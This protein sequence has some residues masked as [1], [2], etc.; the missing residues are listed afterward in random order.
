MKKVSFSAPVSVPIFRLAICALLI[1]S[2]SQSANARD[3]NSSNPSGA[4]FAT[5]AADGGRLF[6]QRS[7]VLG[8]NVS[9][10]LTIDGKPAGTLT[11]GRTYDRYIRPGRH[12]LTASPNRSRG[13]W[14][15]TLNVR[16]GETYS[17]TA[18]FNVTKL[19]LTPVSGSR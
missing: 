9:I 13:A 16:P 17:Y 8:R 2:A 14:Q 11:W 18:S 4:I 15:G 7:P 5:S 10:T 19:V 12:T 1:A 3:K 6:I